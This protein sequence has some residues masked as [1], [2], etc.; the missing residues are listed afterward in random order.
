MLTLVKAE[1]ACKQK[2]IAVHIS[3]N[4]THTKLIPLFSYTMK[5]QDHRMLSKY[6]KE[7]CI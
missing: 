1:A 5:T 7:L 6:Q 2:A 4:K 3:F